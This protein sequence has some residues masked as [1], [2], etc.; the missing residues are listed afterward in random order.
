MNG[1]R[2]KGWRPYVQVKL[3]SL[4]S[5]IESIMQPIQEWECTMATAKYVLA[6]HRIIVYIWEETE[7]MRNPSYFTKITSTHMNAFSLFD[8]PSFRFCSRLF[9]GFLSH[10]LL[11]WFWFWLLLLPLLLLL[12]FWLCV[13][14]CS[15]WGHWAAES[16]IFD[17]RNMTHNRTHESRFSVTNYRWAVCQPILIYFIYN[18]Y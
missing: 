3:S 15:G 14:V 11:I 4:L 17:T 5:C 8:S 9:L 10:S 13:C 12:L 1:K 16:N 6:A 2:R 7:K 18:F